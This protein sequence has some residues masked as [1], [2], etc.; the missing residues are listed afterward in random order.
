MSGATFTDGAGGGSYTYAEDLTAGSI[1]WFR[2]FAINDK[3]KEG[4]TPDDTESVE[5][6]M[7][8]TEAP[9][10]P[11]A[12]QYLVAETGRDANS[13]QRT[14]LGVD[15]LWDQG[16]LASGDTIMGY[17]V[18][19]KVND[20]DWEQLSSSP[21]TGDDYTQYTDIDEPEA[22]EVRAYRVAAVAS[23]GQ[24]AWSNVAYNPAMHEH[25]PTEPTNVMA[26]SD[27]AG[28]LMLTW[29][30]GANADSYLLIAVNMADT[31][32]Y[33]TMIV[34]DGAAQMGTVTG[35]TSGVN[36]LGIVVALQGTGADQTF[37]YGASG[38]QAVQ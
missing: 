15:L 32:D 5:P 29:E 34:S 35:L 10:K 38:V 8:K 18:D 1:R 17:V 16:D 4:P 14:E 24:G 3:N 20:G 11:G 28:E 33:E 31:S 30:G 23:G 25:A 19:R 21:H 13:E 37:A 7:G 27:A 36:Y 6:K 22:D 2:V 9:A 26:S 12:P